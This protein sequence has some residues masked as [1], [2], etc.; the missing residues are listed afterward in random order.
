MHHRIPLA[1][2]DVETTGLDPSE[3]RIAEIGVVTVDGD[4]AERWT[5]RLRVPRYRALD[6]CLDS[7]SPA[8]EDAPRFADIASNLAQR[9]SGRLFVAHN[10]R[11]DHAFL[12]A[13]FARVGVVFD[14]QVGCSVMLSRKLHPQ[15]AHHDLDSLAAWP[16][17][18]PVGIRERSDLHVVDHWQF[19]G[20]ARS[21][22]ELHAVLDAPPHAFDPRLHRLLDRTL[23]RLPRHKIVDLSAY[24][25]QDVRA[26]AR[27]RA[28]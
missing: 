3:D 27:D 17:R 26:S 21:E 28:A 7:P 15:L 20:T 25:A 23:A 1:F 2:V 5:S 19:L 11:F 8:V 6:S 22:S 16:H 12:R 13:E 18:G 9:L 24:R 4:S 10:A 14:P